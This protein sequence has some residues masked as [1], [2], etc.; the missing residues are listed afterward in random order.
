MNIKV[1]ITGSTGMVGEGVLYECILNPM[2]ESVLLINRR[3]GNVKHEKV[4]EV[5]HT[6]FTDF[7]MIADQLVG[8]DAAYLCMGVSSVGMKEDQYQRLTFDFTI[9]LARV[10]QKQNPSMTV[11]YVSGVGT[12]STEKGR[13]MWARV[14]GKTENSLLSLFPGKAFMFRPGYIQP[15][16]GLKNTYTVYKYVGLLYPVWKFLFSRYVTSL[17]ELGTAM[18]LVS[19]KGHGKNVLESRDINALAKS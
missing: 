2:V 4:K 12:D 18:I 5:I 8:Y 16:E 14:K 19:L 9:A 10:L 6:D 1:I 15:T 3:P 17:R 13:V 11:C 7:G